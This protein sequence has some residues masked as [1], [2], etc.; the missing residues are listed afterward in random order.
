MI[1]Q[2]I[3]LLRGS[4]RPL[5]TRWRCSKDPPPLA[6]IQ[7]KFY[8]QTHLNRVF[9]RSQQ[10]SGNS[11]RFTRFSSSA[12]AEPAAAE[13]TSTGK[14]TA[15]VIVFG[16]I[17]CATAGL[18]SWQI[19]RY[20][21]KKDLVEERRKTLV[22][23]P[24]KVGALPK[25]AEEAK[26]YEFRPIMLT[27][28]FDHANEILVGPR[29]P[30][31]DRSGGMGLADVK[32]ETAGFFV[33][34]PFVLEGDGGDKILV[35]RGWIP[36]SFA[37]KDKTEYASIEGAKRFVD[38]VVEIVGILTP[39]E[40]KHTFSPPNDIK[41]RRFLWFELDG[42]SKA[43]SYV[44]GSEAVSSVGIFQAT[45]SHSEGTFPMVRPIE[46]YN[47]FYTTTNTHLIYAGTWFT[48]ATAGTFMTYRL[49]K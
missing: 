21:W 22:S 39:G 10:T 1:H 43:A 41:N 3:K 15:G 36:G 6:H 17:V 25:T 33:V 37:A 38:G 19:K 28:K 14:K 29:S 5:I 45:K 4:S 24:V 48:L 34:T 47:D 12:G 2:S 16:G 30:P 27:G 13:A 40:E 9:Q 23:Q 46:A 26:K 35:N 42:L 44:D 32:G 49:F 20:F 11:V 7:R 31:K 18:G 8:T